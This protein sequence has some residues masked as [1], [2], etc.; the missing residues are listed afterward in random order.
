MGRKQNSL[1]IIDPSRQQA[2]WPMA[3]HTEICPLPSCQ[4]PP[5]LREHEGQGRGLVHNSLLMQ[6]KD[7]G[8]G[9]GCEQGRTCRC[10]CFLIQQR[11]RGLRAPPLPSSFA[12]LLADV[13]CSIFVL[14]SDRSSTTNVPAFYFHIPFRQLQGQLTSE[15][16]TPALDLS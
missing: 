1:D 5:S 4:L 3:V 9:S 10:I 16:L 8:A 6:P 14:S 7:L 15:F 13:I 11:P 2:W 12:S